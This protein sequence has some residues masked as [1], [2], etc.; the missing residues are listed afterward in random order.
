MQVNW[1][2]RKDVQEKKFFGKTVKF[3]NKYFFF[4]RHIDD[5]NIILITN[6]IVRIKGSYCLL[7]DNNKA[8]FLKDWQIR[9]IG[10]WQDGLIS[11]YAV[12][13]N[14]NFFK[15]YT[16]SNDFEGYLFDKALTFDDLVDIAKQQDEV[17]MPIR[18]I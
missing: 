11:Q 16:F 14:R 7:V 8:V 15:I 4:Q 18:K 9:E 2:T 13:L 1:N 3:T 6:N 5:D 12:K 10:F 17:G